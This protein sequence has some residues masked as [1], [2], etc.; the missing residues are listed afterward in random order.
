MK[1]FCAVQPMFCLRNKIISSAVNLIM[2]EVI[3]WGDNQIHVGCYK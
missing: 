2:G 1:P 3:R